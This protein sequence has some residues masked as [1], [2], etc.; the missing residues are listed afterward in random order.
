M[1]IDALEQ[2]DKK[3]TSLTENILQIKHDQIHA[4]QEITE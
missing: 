1:F 3:V 4:L 2:K